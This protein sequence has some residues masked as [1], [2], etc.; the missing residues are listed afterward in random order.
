MYMLNLYL[1]IMI[2]KLMRGYFF[3][4]NILNLLVVIFDV[5]LVWWGRVGNED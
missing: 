2:K 3:L 5:N 1:N 4:E